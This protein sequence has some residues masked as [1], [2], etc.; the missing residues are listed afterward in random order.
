M[1]ISSVTIPGLEGSKARAKSIHHVELYPPDADGIVEVQHHFD[2]RRSR[3]ESHRFASGDEAHA[4]IWGLPDFGGEH[5]DEMGDTADV[6][7]LGLDDDQRESGR[8]QLQEQD[9]RQP[10]EVEPDS[11]KYDRGRESNQMLGKRG[12][13]LSEDEKR[14]TP[15]TIP[16]KRAGSRSYRGR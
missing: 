10:R 12:V 11:S 5:G 13:T 6:A 3:P 14:G 9:Y 2:D 4:H 15:H 7:R 16:Y 1:R 8:G